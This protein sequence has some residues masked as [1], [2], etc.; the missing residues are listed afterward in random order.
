MTVKI[1]VMILAALGSLYTIFL[2][3]VRRR[4]ANNPTPANVADVY[5]AETYAKWKEYGAEHSRLELIF[6]ILTGV[7]TLAMLFTNVYAVWRERVCSTVGGGN[8]GN[9]RGICCGYSA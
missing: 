8:I 9:S 2:N 1:S 7:I 3:V 6:S 5:D 4:S